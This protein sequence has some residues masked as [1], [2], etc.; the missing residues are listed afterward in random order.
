MKRSQ[1]L[2][3]LKKAEEDPKLGA[4]VLAAVERGGQLTAAEIL[5][6]AE[7]F[8]YKFNRNEFEKEVKRAFAARFAAVQDALDTLEA[9]KPR[10]P[11]P[12]LS[13]CARG[14]LS[15]TISWHPPRDI[16]IK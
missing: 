8:G 1:P 5:Q 2:E 14:C 11:R 15:Y 7:E 12:P 6:I 10:R 16:I 3:F 9:A 4:R 13:S